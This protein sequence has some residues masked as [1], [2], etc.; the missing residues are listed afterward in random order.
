MKYKALQLY[1]RYGYLIWY[2]VFGGVTVLANLGVYALCY[3]AIGIPNVPSNIIA[4]FVS[5]VVA[6]CTNKHFVFKSTD[7]SWSSLKHEAAGFF[8][9]RGISGIFDV[10]A[11]FIAVD[12]L[13]RNSIISK[14]IIS[15]AVI[16]INLFGARI[17]VF[18]DQFKNESAQQGGAV[19]QTRK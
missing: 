5:T 7:W 18:R 1:A 14:L 4:W 16:V 15:I 10:F 12:V 19:T 3:H 13:H 11:L 17:I 9:I 6:F 2:G 8:G